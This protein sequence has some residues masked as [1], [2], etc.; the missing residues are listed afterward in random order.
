MTK[1]REVF[2]SVDVETAGPIPGEYS[3]L[4][5]G[6]CNIEDPTDTFSCALKPITHHADPAALEVTGLSLVQLEQDGLEPAVGM[7]LFG[8]WVRQSAGHDGTPI[9]VGF[10]AS[11]DWSFINYYFHLYLGENPFGFAALDIKSMYMGAARSSWSN[12]RSSQIA[13]VLH[14]TLSG[15][16]DALHDAQYQAELFRLIQK[17]K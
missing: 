6:A 1:N 17:V 14:P 11:F 13:A 7:Q 4:T 2:L 5:I 3:L 9:F 10:N 15:D 12:T 8:E 16:H